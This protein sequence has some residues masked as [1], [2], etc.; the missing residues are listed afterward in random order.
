MQQKPLVVHGVED[1]QGRALF[2]VSALYHCVDAVRER[3][4]RFIGVQS[5]AVEIAVGVLH[6]DTGVQVEIVPEDQNEDCLRSAALYVAVALDDDTAALA[7]T[8][9]APQTPRLVLM[10]FPPYE[11][12]TPN[13]IPTLGAAHSPRRFAELLRGRLC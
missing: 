12:L 7:V 2:V 3:P 11:R 5:A 13:A 4:I 1:E 6:F 8:G 9:V 10:Q